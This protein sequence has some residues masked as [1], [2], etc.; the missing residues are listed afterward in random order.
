MIDI[1]MGATRI[2]TFDGEALRQAREAK[3][4]NRGRL[5]NAVGKTVA[6]VSGW[7]RNLRT[8]EAKTLVD[9]ADALDIDASDLI[10]LPRAEWRMSEYRVTKGL[11]QIQA[12]KIIGI[13][14]DRFSYLEAAYE[15]PSEDQMSAL[16]E[17]Y[18][19]SVKEI[20]AAWERTSTHLRTHGDDA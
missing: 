3:G 1:T 4:W 2:P 12:A 6:S 7:E 14:A 9:L 5:A 13:P 16:A 18:D 10:A 20:S 19:V 17:L 15:R 11:Q 8:P